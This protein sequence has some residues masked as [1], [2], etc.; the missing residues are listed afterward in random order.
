MRKKKGS[1]ESGVTEN[2]VATNAEVSKQ[3]KPLTPRPN[4][5]ETPL[6]KTTTKPVGAFKDLNISDGFRLKQAQQVVDQNK[7]TSEEKVTVSYTQPFTLE[8]LQQSVIDYTKKMQEQ[9]KKQIATMLRPEVISVQ[10]EVEIIIG[11]E[12]K[13]QQDG[14]EP[15]KQDFLDHVRKALNNQTI[16]MRMEEKA[17]DPTKRAYSPSEKFETML[18]KNPALL[19]L[20]NRL[21]MELDY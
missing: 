12:N 6:Q 18:L 5:T 17:A 16:T 2:E 15:M 19:T 4:V 14:F 8:Q 21:G 9:G 11:I 20:K 10:N 1:T 3:D 13:A 7:Q